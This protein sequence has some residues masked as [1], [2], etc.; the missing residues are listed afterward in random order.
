MGSDGLGG[1]IS[2]FGGEEKLCSDP[3]KG[4]AGSDG[5]SHTVRSFGTA[6]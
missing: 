6:P 4:P 5:D 1:T 3:E 2:L